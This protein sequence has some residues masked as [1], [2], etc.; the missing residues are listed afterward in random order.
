MERQHVNC[1]QGQ[2]GDD[3]PVRAAGGS[4]HLWLQPQSSGANRLQSLKATALNNVESTCPQSVF[5]ITPPGV[6][7]FAPE[8]WQNWSASCLFWRLHP[9]LPRHAGDW[10]F[11][12]QVHYALASVFKSKHWQI[13][14]S[15]LSS[16]SQNDIPVCAGDHRHVSE[17]G[18][19][20]DRPDHHQLWDIHHNAAQLPTTLKFTG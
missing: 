19:R 6:P 17:W 12:W 2:V 14:M 11:G 15:G 1:L 20:H 16:L 13:W 3:K 8:V 9:V 4:H 5:K 7:S 10:V 18:P